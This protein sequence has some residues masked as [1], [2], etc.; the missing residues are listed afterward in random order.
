MHILA[1]VNKNRKT[2]FLLLFTS[3][4]AFILIIFSANYSRGQFGNDISKMSDKQHVSREYSFLYPTD[5]YIDDKTDAFLPHIRITNLDLG[6]AKQP[7]FLT[8]QYFKFELV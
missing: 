5:W 2:Y 4:S 1:L 7:E 8:E 6:T 3:L